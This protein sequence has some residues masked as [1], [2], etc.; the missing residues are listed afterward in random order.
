LQTAR[1]KEELIKHYG[2]EFERVEPV[3]SGDTFKLGKRTLTFLEAPML[4]LA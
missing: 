4:H 2:S 1:G 3:K